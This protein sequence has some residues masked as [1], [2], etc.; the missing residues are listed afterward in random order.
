MI[1]RGAEIICSKAQKSKK[2][3]SVM[4]VELHCQGFLRP[5]RW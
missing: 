2:F 3:A 1:L 4:D 5:R